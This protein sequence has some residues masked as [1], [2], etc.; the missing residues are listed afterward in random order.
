MGRAL[1]MLLMT[2]LL[3][4]CAGSP[5]ADEAQDESQAAPLQLSCYQTAWQ[6]ETVQVID[7][8]GGQD[9]W[10]RYDPTAQVGNVGCR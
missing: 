3:A 10:D 2:G 9:F 8:R 7:K 1:P 4:G 5:E 6:A